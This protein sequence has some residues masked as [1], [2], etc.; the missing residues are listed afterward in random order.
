M[1]WVSGSASPQQLEFAEVF[2]RATT[3]AEGLVTALL[4]LGKAEAGI[5]PMDNVDLAEI[6]GYVAQRRLA[7]YTSTG[8]Q[9]DSVRAP[10]RSLL[11]AEFLLL[12]ADVGDDSLDLV[13][14]DVLDGTVK[15]PDRRPRMPRERP[16]ALQ[17][18]RR[19]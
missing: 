8:L 19:T 11:E 13:V 6:V 16:S 7:A 15:R 9:S 10:G 1:T 17:Q 5:G 18:V 2:D 4:Q 3:R 12:C 14:G